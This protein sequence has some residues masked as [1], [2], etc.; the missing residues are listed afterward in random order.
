MEKYT[1]KLG[2]HASSVLLPKELFFPTLSQVRYDIS[3]I[4]SLSIY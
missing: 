4:A 3:P 2:E 1:Q